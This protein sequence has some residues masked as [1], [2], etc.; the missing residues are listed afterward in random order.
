MR[1]IMMYQD[2]SIAR[3][4]SSLD[5]YQKTS[6]DVN[7]KQVSG[8]KNQTTTESNNFGFELDCSIKYGY[9]GIRPLEF[10]NS[11]R[12]ILLMITHKSQFLNP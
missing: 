7:V 5:H 2:K 8:E 9:N 11:N 6:T 4:S 1:G 12:D 10:I 3:R